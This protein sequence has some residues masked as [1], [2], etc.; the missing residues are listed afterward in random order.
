MNFTFF[1]TP[2]V[3]SDTW[4]MIE[5]LTLSHVSKGDEKSKQNGR[6][7]GWPCVKPLEVGN[8]NIWIRE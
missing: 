1:E 3:A 8:P 4:H 5:L 6:S 7:K 2:N